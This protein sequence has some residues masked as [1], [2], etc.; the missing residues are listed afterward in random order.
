MT[1]YILAY[2][3]IVSAG[4][5]HKDAP[6]VMVENEQV[7]KKPAD[8]APKQAEVVT[9]EDRTNLYGE[10]DEN[11]ARA[12]LTYLGKTL[13]FHS[14]VHHV[15]KDSK[16]YFVALQ[17]GGR[18]PDG[19]GWSDVICYAADPRTVADF[20]FSTAVTVRGLCEG[21]KQAAGVS[22]KGWHVILTDCQ[23]TQLK[24]SKP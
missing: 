5:G 21:R 17:V 20:K 23:V 2:L 16:G 8:K 15:G 24:K 12:D 10:Y 9:L 18:G 11:Q 19:T 4:C 3:L 7:E 1:R 13:E 6:A 22:W 14:A